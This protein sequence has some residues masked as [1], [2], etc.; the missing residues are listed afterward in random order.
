M[1]MFS[2]LSEEGNTIILITH[3][4]DI[5]RCTQRLIRLRDGKIESDV[6]G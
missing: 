5:A 2:K 1:K 6:R 3:E 4:E